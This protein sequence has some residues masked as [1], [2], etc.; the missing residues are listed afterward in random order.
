M[1]G[2]V[3]PLYNERVRSAEHPSAASRLSCSGHVDRPTGRP[4]RAGVE[5]VNGAPPF[6]PQNALNC[7]L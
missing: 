7:A 3:T 5:R 1:M 6:T 2:L 4:T